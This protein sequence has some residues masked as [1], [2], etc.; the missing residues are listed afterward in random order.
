[1][2]I[3]H[4]RHMVDNMEIICKLMNSVAKQCGCRVKYNPKSRSPQF[5]GDPDCIE[6]IVEEALSYFQAG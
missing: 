1:M 5:S 6:Y 4:I 2:E 3:L